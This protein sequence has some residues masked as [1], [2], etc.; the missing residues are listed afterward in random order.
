MNILLGNEDSVG[1]LNYS[2]WERRGFGVV[3]ISD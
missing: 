3:I 1:C 2:I